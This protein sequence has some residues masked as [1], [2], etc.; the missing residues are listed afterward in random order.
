MSQILFSEVVTFVRVHLPNLPQ[1]TIGTHLNLMLE[2]IYERL[3]LNYYSTFTTRAATT[4]GTV[5]VTA[6]STAVTFSS[7]VLGASDGMRVFQSNGDST[8]YV[9]TRTNATTGVLSS[10][11]AGATDAT[12]TY[13]ILYPTVTFGAGVGTILRVGR[14]NT[15]LELDLA[16]GAARNRVTMGVT[17]GIPLYYAP[18]A[19]DDG[20]TPN[21]AHRIILTPFP[22]TAQ[23]YEYEYDARPTL[24]DPSAADPTTVSVAIPTTFRKPLL[25]GTLGLCWL[26]EDQDS[27]DRWTSK[28]EE[29]IRQAMA[30]KSKEV[31]GRR[32]GLTN[33]GGRYVYPDP[34]GYRV[35][36]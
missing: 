15:N 13:T 8:W 23:A 2:E 11:Y 19:F 17:S 3:A 25:Y 33:R 36:P 5:S 14:A 16:A 22:N 26:R 31:S 24:V 32:Q 18:Y 4:T 29:A 21:D 34:D 28:A 12:A 1:L 20:A 10:A 35:T 6:G 7:G 27:S 30:T 9:L